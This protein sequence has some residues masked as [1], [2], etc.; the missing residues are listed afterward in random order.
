MLCALNTVSAYF[1][2]SS[3]F[4]GLSGIRMSGIN[5]CLSGIN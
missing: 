5:Q 2:Q 1:V 4:C 3:I